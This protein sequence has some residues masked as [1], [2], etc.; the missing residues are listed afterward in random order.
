M[1]H[2]VTPIIYSCKCFFL[3][4]FRDAT[5]KKENRRA[6]ASSICEVGN[7]ESTALGPDVVPICNQGL[8]TL[9]P[10]DGVPEGLA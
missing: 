10:V 7:L 9:S 2:F 6:V 8:L 1:L 5:A 4:V 3:D